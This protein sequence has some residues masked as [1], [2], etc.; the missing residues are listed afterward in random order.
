MQAK[1]ECVSCIFNQALRVCQN[2]GAS[3]QQTKEVLD[4][5][6]QRVKDFDLTQTPP[7][8][9]QWVY[10]LIGKILDKK[11]LYK[12]QKLEATIA[13]TNSIQNL[14]KQF[15]SAQD[16]LLFALK[17][18]VVGNVIDLASQ[19]NFDLDKEVAEVF[20]TKFAIDHYKDFKSK[21]FHAKSLLIIGDNAGEHIFDSFMLKIFN[22]LDPDKKYYFATRNRPIIN[23]ITYQEALQSPLVDLCEVIN[24]GVNTPGL[25]ISQASDQFLQL[26]SSA[27]LV[28][29]KGMGNYESLGYKAGREVFHLLKVKCNV[30]AHDLRK[31]VGDI[32]F[33]K[34]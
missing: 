15:D 33:A 7:S 28:I 23:D 30:V 10:E 21:F 20:D 1:A 24:S 19:H 6:G 9:A 29:A 2:V 18:S 26:L 5:V 32:I 22:S 14:I 8:I 34:L 11:D 16:P 31:E 13:A 25:E 4:A 17:S 12:T 27:D 3:Q